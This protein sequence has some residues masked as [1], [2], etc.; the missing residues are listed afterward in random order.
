MGPQ[1]A[2]QGNLISLRVAKYPLLADLLVLMKENIHIMWLILAETVSR[3]Y[4]GDKEGSEK[5]GRVAQISHK[6][7]FLG[8]LFSNADYSQDN[9]FAALL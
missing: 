9:A 6:T 5:R 7:D 8:I 2:N 1:I 4:L 3:R